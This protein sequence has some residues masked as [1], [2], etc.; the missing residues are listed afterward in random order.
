MT[1]L[2]N[3]QPE[4][5]ARFE[6]A[7]KNAVIEEWDE[8]MP[9]SKSGLIHIEYQTGREGSLDFLTIWASTIRGYWSLVCE[10]WMRPLWSQ[11]AG[12]TFHNDY[13]SLCFAHGLELVMQQHNG[14]LN[15]PDRRGLIQV[16]PP[17][18]VEGST[19]AV[20]HNPKPTPAEQ[21]VAA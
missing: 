20:G 12:L 17:Q 11:A 1:A 16:Y 6:C 21:L 18:E 3:S 14:H 9:D 8:L 7:L 10:Q 19:K 5:P 13:H 4:Q 2:S 15:L